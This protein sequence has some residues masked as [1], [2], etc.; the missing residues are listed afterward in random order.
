MDT[1]LFHVGENILTFKGLFDRLSNPEIVYLLGKFGV[2]L[3]ADFA[4][5]IKLPGMLKLGSWLGQG[6]PFYS[7]NITYHSDFKF[8][9]SP[10]K[11]YLL[12]IPN[13]AATL[14]EVR[15]NNNEP[16]IIGMTDGLKDITA[17]LHDG[18]NSIEIKLFGSR[19]NAFGPLHITED[20]PFIIGSLTFQYDAE[21]WQ[22][23][24]KLV[25]YGL[26]ATP[27]IHQVDL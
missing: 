8:N 16:V 11:R 3:N 4:E 9:Y 2:F 13:I 18:K 12:D 10:Y 15:I 20:E 19:R 26:L 21:N 17:Y 1:D 25:D 14:S 23:A 7:G 6:L 27:V 5:I 22:E 24:Y